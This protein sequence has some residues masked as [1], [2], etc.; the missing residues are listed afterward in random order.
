MAWMRIAIV[1]FLAGCYKSGTD[2]PGPN[3]GHYACNQGLC[4]IACNEEGKCGVKNVVGLG[5]MC[6]ARDDADCAQSVTCKRDGLCS[7]TAVGKCIAKRAAD[8]EASERC[9]DVGH[10]SLG[11]PTDA[12]AQDKCVVNRDD[13]C[14]QSTPCKQH[15]QCHAADTALPTGGKC[16]ARTITR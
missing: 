12:Y 14:A 9:R 11:D 15:G 6:V 10:C 3:G 5:D 7:A 13:D 16:V 1:M 4:A 2:C 8:C